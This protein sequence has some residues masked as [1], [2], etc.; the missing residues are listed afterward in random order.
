MF[1]QNYPLIRLIIP[2]TLGM[3]GAN[4]FI[5]HM[6]LVV[7]FILCCVVLAFSFFELRT[8]NFEKDSKFG[9]VA[10]L[11]FFLIG[12]NW[13]TGKYRHVENGIPADTTFVQGTLV[14]L[15]KEKPHSWAL[16]LELE[17]GTHIILYY[18]CPL[19][20]RH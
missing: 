3:I 14:E 2:F 12:M 1:W 9:L 17:N 10:M 16:E 4:L 15:P 6:N 8:S 18:Y 13:Y 19:N 20:F 5:A 11:L 7:L